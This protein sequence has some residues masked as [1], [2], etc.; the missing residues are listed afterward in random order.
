LEKKK[1]EEEDKKK[2]EEEEKKKKKEEED[3]K[4]K[5]EEDKKKNTTTT[6]TTP[7]STAP[8]VVRSLLRGNRTTTTENKVEEKKVEEK[9]VE[10]KVEEKKVEEKK[11]ELKTENISNISKTNPGKLTIKVLEGKELLT[12]NPFCN[13]LL[14]NSKLRRKK[15]TTQYGDKNPKWNDSFLF[16]LTDILLSE[17]EIGV[18]DRK[19]TKDNEFGSVTIIINDLG[20]VKDEEKQQWFKLNNVKSGSLLLGF[21][22]HNFGKIKS[23]TEVKES[24][25]VV[26]E[27]SEKEKRLE[28]RQKR[29]QERQNRMMQK[30][31]ENKEEKKELS[32]EDKKVENIIEVLRET[33]MIKAE[34]LQMISDFISK[35]KVDWCNE[36]MEQGGIQKLSL[37]LLKTDKKTISKDE[38]L[39]QESSI[40]IFESLL[41]FDSSL[42]YFITSTDLSRSLTLILNGTSL[43]LQKT[44]LSILFRISQHNEKGFWSILDGFNNY[45]MVKKENI[46]FTDLIKS[47][48]EKDDDRYRINL[49]LLLNSFFSKNQD[50]STSNYLKKELNS[51]NLKTILSKLK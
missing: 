34:F 20:L 51:L 10:E 3:K 4:K 27:L 24:K 44:I 15:T 29:L 2:K 36:F 5:E 1:K 31:S 18:V 46:R 47:L 12:E 14:L 41:N 39:I 50:K 35:C 32:E 25:E 43:K 19:S 33:D 40:K 8:K 16:D 17:F 28:E 38:N 30:E 13:L 45:K 21:T 9:K 7:T 37:L 26:K 42:N 11:V 22:A 49:L 48:E 6:T 23:S